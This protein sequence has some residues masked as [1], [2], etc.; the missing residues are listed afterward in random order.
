VRSSFT[1]CRTTARKRSALDQSDITRA[2]SA[3]DFPG[4]SCDDPDLLR[5]AEQLEGR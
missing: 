5:A 4:D 1:T 2:Y 3:L